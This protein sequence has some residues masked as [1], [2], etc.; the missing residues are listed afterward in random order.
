LPGF[1]TDN[2]VQYC[3]QVPVVAIFTKCDGLIT[4]AFNELRL[5]G[6]SIGQANKNSA[7]VAAAKLQTNFIAP[8]LATKFRPSDHLQAASQSIRAM[9]E[10]RTHMFYRY[11]WEQRQLQRAD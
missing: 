9:R 10:T 7:D 5:K 2:S 1:Q 11:A 8:L 6:S 4:K 3:F